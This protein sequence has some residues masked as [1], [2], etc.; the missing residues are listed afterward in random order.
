M[1]EDGEQTYKFDNE[2]SYSLSSC[3]MYDFMTICTLSEGEM[4]DLSPVS[5]TMF[6]CS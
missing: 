1:Q 5:C 4:I 6:N 3:S 2:F